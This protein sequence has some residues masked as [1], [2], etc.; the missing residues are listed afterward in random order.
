MDQN[1]NEKAVKNIEEKNKI[2]QAALTLVKPEDAIIVASGST[3][4][5]FGRALDT[6]L[7]INVVTPSLG[8][9]FLLNDN[10]NVNV[11]ILGGRVYKKS[12]S[13]RGD[14]A[15]EGLNNVSCSKLFIGCDGIDT[16]T[17]ITCATVE[18]AKLTNNMMAAATQTVV[19]A[20]SS[21]FG[22]RGFGKICKLE[23]IDIIITDAG[24]PEAIQEEIEEAGVQIIIA[25]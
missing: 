7:P 20:D 4:T 5:A 12:L 9:A 14:Y 10:P 1:I 19:L 8:I 6:N 22:R 11:M 21:K 2:G 25:E 13:V 18:E 17:G 15:A 24:I 16:E 23:D 3:C